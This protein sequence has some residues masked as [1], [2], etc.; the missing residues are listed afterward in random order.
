MLL[1]LVAI[2]A[3]GAVSAS[4]AMAT[5]HWSD[6][7]HGMKVSGALNVSTA[8]QTTKTCTAT[9]SQESL[10]TTNTAFVG[11]SGKEFSYLTFSCAGGGTFNAYFNMVAETTTAVRLNK[12]GLS[13]TAPWGCC[14]SPY[15]QN[16]SPVGDFVNGSG[17]TSS[18]LTFGGSSDFIGTYEPFTPVYIS[19]TLNVTTSTGGLLTLLP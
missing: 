12:S 18:T 14:G 17:S 3:V 9:S 1:M 19:G 15:T 5:V 16:A 7:T 8:G 10:L 4:S 2:G 6:T 13:E 11:T